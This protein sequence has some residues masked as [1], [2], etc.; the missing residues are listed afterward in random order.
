MS[1]GAAN[2]ITSLLVA[3]SGGDSAALARLMPLTYRTLREIATYLMRRERGEHTLQ[4]TALVHEAYL[5]LADLERIGWQNRAHFY[6]MSARLMRRV[7]VEHARR[8]SRA[9]RGGG[10]PQ[11]SLDDVDYGVADEQ[12]IDIISLDDALRDLAAL[13]VERARIVELRFFGG[14]EGHEIAEVLSVSS[15]TV[16]RRWRSARAWLLRYLTEARA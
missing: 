2:E 11:V 7:L 4:T 12:D 3:W 10:A 16:Q 14:L 1:S 13:D 15:A 8:R 9:K 5:R 6:A